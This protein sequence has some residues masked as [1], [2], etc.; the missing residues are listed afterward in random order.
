MTESPFLPPRRA[1]A[2][3]HPP[4]NEVSILELLNLALRTRRR[5]LVG[6]LS[7]SALAA[8]F[9]LF[10]P[11]KWASESSF[12]AQSRRVPSGLSG[13]A[14]QLGLSM[15]GADAAQ[16]PNFYADVATSR[17]ILGELVDASYE[18]RTTDSVVTG[19]LV[20][21]LR[22]R[23]RTPAIRRENAMRQ[24]AKMITISPNAKTSVVRVKVAAEAPDLA[25]EINRRLFT[26]LDQF[27]RERRQSQAAA[28][29]QFTQK[30]VEA[31]EQILRD[32]EGR[33]L[34]FLQR[35]RDYRNSPEL[36][37][38]Y[39]RLARDIQM[40]QQLFTTL[41][42][43]YEQAKLE[44]VRDTPVI[45]M[46]ESPTL[47]AKP[48]PRGAVVRL[49]LGFIIGVAVMLAWVV[50]ETGLGRRRAAGSPEAADFDA[51]LV[52]TI[53]ELKRLFRFSGNKRQA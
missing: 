32:A 44:E 38:Q 1:E 14:A 29:R 40:Q 50:F 25:Q 26:S 6:A 4:A 52:E 48:Q 28:E 15:P 30:R 10:T 22:V 27:N 8:L 41:V 21:L 13:V 39:D 33:M 5:L 35:N 16:S 9:V 43:A 7:G 45:T 49:A 37:A 31:T 47:A 53:N 42:Q 17:D 23:G 36:T 20:L 51:L 3:E 18:V 11:Q 46:V 24:L 12:V 34:L 19:D 2:A